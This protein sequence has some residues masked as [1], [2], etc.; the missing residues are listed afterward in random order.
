MPKSTIFFHFGCFLLLF[1]LS[2][3]S[4]EENSSVTVGEQSI[5]T[6]SSQQYIEGK[7]DP[8]LVC[9]V[10]NAYMGGKEQLPIE[11]EGKTYYGCCE[12]CVKTIKTDRSVRYAQDP[13][14]G[15]EVDKAVAFITKV[16]G[17]Q[18]EVLYFESLENY[19][20]YLSLTAE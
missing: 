1:T 11:F 16:P 6:A 7:L 19:N 12:M 2:C 8:K 3:N 17:S 4:P 15:K 14:T 13:L 9:M 20:R 10:N 18:D 5:I